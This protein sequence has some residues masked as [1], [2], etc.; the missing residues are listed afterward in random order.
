MAYNSQ[1][2]RKIEHLLKPAFRLIY[3]HFATELVL[4]F[5]VSAAVGSNFLIRA[6]IG[7]SHNRSLFFSYL[8]KHP[9]LNEQL[10]RSSENIEL[11]LHQ[12]SHSL[13]KQVLAASTKD[14]TDGVRPAAAGLPTLSG[15]ALLKPNPASTGQPLPTPGRDIEVYRVEAGDTVARIASSYGVSEDTIRWEN[16]LPASGLIHTGDELKILPTSGLTHT[17]KEGETLSAIAKKYKV[18]P[19]DILDYNYMEDEDFVVAGTELIIPDGV[20]EAPPVPKVAARPDDVKKYDVPANFQPSISG[21]LWPVPASSHLNQKFSRRHPG[22]DVQARY[23]PII[24]AAEGIVELAGWQRGYGYTIVVNHGNGL[25]TRYA[26]ASKLLVAAGDHVDSGQQI[27]VSGNTGRSTGPHLHYEII[28]NGARV[29]P[30]SS[31]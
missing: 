19:E 5:I 25:K 9:A 18:D 7:T 28:K 22:I 26:H 12:S 4:V 30:M 31:Y 3:S 15:S 13:V 11:A 14:K 6:Q 17:V 8:K 10:A 20:K 21:L 2:R 24:T 16:N 1:F 27:M 29:N 23:V